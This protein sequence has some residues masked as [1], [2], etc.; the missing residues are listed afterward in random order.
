MQTLVGTFHK[1]GLSDLKC[2]HI[3]DAFIQKIRDNKNM[4]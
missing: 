1:I 3:Q 2:Q 4:A